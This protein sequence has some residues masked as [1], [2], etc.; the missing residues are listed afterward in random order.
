MVNVYVNAQEALREVRGTLAQRKAESSAQSSQSAVVRA[1]LAA[2][3]Q[4]QI[5]GI[6]G[7]LGA[8]PE[9][10]KCKEHME[11]LPRRLAG[12]NA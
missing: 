9:P 10:S 7:R 4:G 5:P 8:L 11:A 3:S 2:K 1:L 12:S 6:H